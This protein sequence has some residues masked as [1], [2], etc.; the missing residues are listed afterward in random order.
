M[1]ATSEDIIKPAQGFR[2]HLILDI[3]AQ[4]GLE[5]HVQE[6][7]LS[8]GF[9]VQSIP[10]SDAATDNRFPRP[11][12]QPRAGYEGQRECASDR[13]RD[14]ST[15]L[16]GAGEGTS[17]LACSLTCSIQRHRCLRRWSTTITRQS[18]PRSHCWGPIPVA[19]PQLRLY[20][21]D[22]PHLYVE[23]NLYGMY[24]FGYGN[25]VSI[26]DEIGRDSDEAL[27]HQC[28]ISVGFEAECE[29]R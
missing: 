1:N 10:S 25:F 27:E 5:V 11:D 28:R 15:T 9:I 24:F 18:R 23:G 29:R 2:V 13:P 4:A 12:I 14:V 26:A 21:T 16:S 22:S 19:G 17:V 7:S 6:P 8:R 20:L 3:R